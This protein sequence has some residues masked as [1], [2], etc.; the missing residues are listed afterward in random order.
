MTNLTVRETLRH[1]CREHVDH[2]VVDKQNVARTVKRLNSFFGDKPVAS[3][4]P[5]Q[6]FDY[7]EHRV[8][9]HGCQSTTVGRE[10]SVLRA[11]GHHCVKWRHMPLGDMPMLEVP[12]VHE[13]RETWLFHDEL[14]TLLLTAAEMCQDPLQRGLSYI[15][16]LYYT[17]S[18]TKA[19]ET[20]RWPQVNASQGRINLLPAGQKQTKKRRPTIPID[21]KLMPTL[22]RC[23]RNRK[24]EYVLGEGPKISTL[25]M[26]IAKKSGL[27]EL[28]ERDTRPPSRLTPHVLR[29]TRITHLLWAGKSAFAVGGLV[30][31]TSATVEK[32][33]GHHAT[34]HL[35]ELFE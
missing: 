29:H 8:N 12:S 34:S 21:P 20:L 10:L 26:A 22:Q 17:G 4:G 28:P 2:K 18:R 32:V 24:D 11:A 19:V 6:C 5:A 30:G 9:D 25:F 15:E 35:K 27:R 1:Y 3:I 16:L 14:E 23:Y 7:L 13:C 33:Y 31:L